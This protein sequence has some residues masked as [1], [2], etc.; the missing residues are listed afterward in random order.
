MLWEKRDKW[1]KLSVIHLCTERVTEKR[2]SRKWWRKGRREDRKEGRARLK[3]TLNVKLGGNHLKKCNQRSKQLNNS[4]QVNGPWVSILNH[5]ITRTQL[6][7]NMNT[8]VRGP[9][10]QRG[11]C[12]PTNHLYIKTSLCCLTA[13]KIPARLRCHKSS[14]VAVLQ[15]EPFHLGMSGLSWAS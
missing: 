5:P 1:Q 4:Q 6:H 11:T 13:A 12:S 7:T 9:D 3:G 14:A 10:A 8:H 15:R 2:G